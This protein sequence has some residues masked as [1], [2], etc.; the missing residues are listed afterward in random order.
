MKEVEANPN[1]PYFLSDPPFK[2]FNVHLYRVDDNT[3]IA[4]CCCCLEGGLPNIRIINQN[5]VT[6]GELV[7]A[8]RDHFYGEGL[9]QTRRV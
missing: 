5:G 1:I 7:P 6:K 8:V 2:K 3:G 4:K 9:E